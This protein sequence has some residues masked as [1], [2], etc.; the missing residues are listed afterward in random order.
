MV[1][2]WRRSTSE[3]LAGPDGQEHRLCLPQEKTGRDYALSTNSDIYIYNIASKQTK[4][5]SFGRY[6]GLRH[7]AQYSPDGKYI[8][9]ISQERDGYESNK[10]R[11]FVED[12]AREKTYLT[13]LIS[14]IMPMRFSG[15]P[16][17]ALYMIAAKRLWHISGKWFG[18]TDHAT[19]HRKMR[20]C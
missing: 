20:F 10:K 17:T 3:D 16:T 2:R 19:Y 8:V 5:N 14:I 18:Q 11:L 4:A 1:I 6:D 7:A 12:L 9:W 13:P 15:H